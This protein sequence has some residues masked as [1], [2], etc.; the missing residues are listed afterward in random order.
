MTLFFK[1]DKDDDSSVSQASHRRVDLILTTLSDYTNFI[2]MKKKIENY[3]TNY[4]N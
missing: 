1:D 3:P 4:A 2:L